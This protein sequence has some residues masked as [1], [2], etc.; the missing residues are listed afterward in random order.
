MIKKTPI[1]QERA[2]RLK[3]GRYLIR[4]KHSIAADIEINNTLP[5]DLAA[6]DKAVQSGELKLL[7]VPSLEE[8]LNDS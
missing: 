4:L 1:E 3:I 2:N 7:G 8:V 5:D 6:F